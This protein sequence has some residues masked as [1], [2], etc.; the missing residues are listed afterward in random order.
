MSLKID[1]VQLEIEIKNDQSRLKMREL[2]GDMKKLKNELKKLPE[3]TAEW[4]KKSEELRKVQAQYDSIIDKIGLTGLS[5]KEL[6]N[7]QR[8]LNQVMQNMDP[9]SASYAQLRTQLDAVN[10][11]M[12]TLRG[13]SQATGLSMGKLADGFNRYFGMLTAFTA[14]FTG[15]FLGFKK[16]IEVANEYGASVAN[17]SAL[18]GLAGD[19]L[20]WLSD[21]AKNLT[22]SGTDSGIA[23][24][25]SA[26]EIVDSY[27][28]MGSAK[29]ELLKNKEALDQVTQQA[30]I[31]AEAAKMEA[32]PAIES[33]ANTMNQFN[34][35]A[36][37]AGRFVNV[38]AAG[39]KEGAAE[40]S[41]ISDSIV[42][43]GAA[44]ASA[45]VSVEESVAMIEA[46]SE[47][48]VKGEI[49]GTALKTMLIRLQQQTDDFNPK[50]VGLNKALENLAGAN[51]ST[52]EM[53]KIFGQESLVQAQ[54]LIENHK[55]V[56]ELE[57]AVTGT[58]T[59][60]E[61]AK[62]NTETNSAAL[63]RAKNAFQLTAIELGEKLAPA[64]TFSTS[65]FSYL[66]KAVVAG[67][68]VWK[69]YSPEIKTAAATIAVYTIAVNAST[70]ADKLKVFWN[71]KVIASF[72]KL[73]TTVS[74]NPYAALLA[75]IPLIIGLMGSLIKRVNESKKQYEGYKFNLDK[76]NAAMD[77]EKAKIDTVFTALKNANPKSQ[78]RA[79]LIKQINE[80]YGKYLP[81]LLSE[82]S[83]LQEIEQ[84]Q[85]AANDAMMDSIVLKMKQDELT[86]L[87]EETLKK[88]REI[89]KSQ[90][91]NKDNTSVT[92]FKVLAEQ[93][94]YF[95]KGTDAYANNLGNMQ[96]MVN[97]LGGSLT[98][99][100]GYAA[101]LKRQREGVNEIETAYNG[102]RLGINS[103]KNSEAEQTDQNISNTNKKNESDEDRNKKLEE[104]WNWERQ[105]QKAIIDNMK[106][107]YEKQ[108]ALEAYTYDGLKHNIEKEIEDKRIRNQ[109][110]EQEA[111]AHHNRLNEIN[112]INVDNIVVEPDGEIPDLEEDPEIINAILTEE[113][114]RKLYQDTEQFKR[115]QLAESLR[116][117]EI[118]QTE[119]NAR[120]A[121][122][123]SAA[124]QTKV[125]GYESTF[126]A[127]SGLLG[128]FGSENKRVVLAQIGFDTA[129][130]VSS[131]M[132]V[133]EANPLN[134]L[135]FGSAG[136]AQWITGLARILGNV[137]KAK[138]ILST[139]G[140]AGGRYPVRTQDGIYN[141]AFGG[142]PSTQVVS[143]PTHF[144]AGEQ[145]PEM[146]VDGPTFKYVRANYP[147]AI[148]AIMHSRAKVRGFADGYYGESSTA[149]QSSEHLTEMIKSMMILLT[150]IDREGVGVS[151]N[152]LTSAQSEVDDIES[153]TRLK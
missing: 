7:R 33:L 83:S 124:W 48:G 99:L 133:A 91:V 122:M 81:N 21:Q 66:M 16:T 112:A 29:P 114:K 11:R 90:V 94:S 143:T 132:K 19:E 138:N 117:N 147:D 38:L 86:Q 115:D 129:S 31:M 60:F 73:K 23:I 84:A 1:R 109:V 121:A 130:A 49:A 62:I 63:E 140:F 95:E 136:M 64:L 120:I 126:S 107:G 82:K 35:P 149:M 77:E 98:A 106:D 118:S 113:Y 39:S 74:V 152:K 8:E 144:V 105:L 96:V 142:S 61:Q 70:I 79:D 88:Q 127:L 146:I 134:S 43:F 93:L 25:A 137:A 58:N 54:I 153:Q 32:T 150:K 27:T 131:L 42:K 34:A 148:N 6:R 85:K 57:T 110:L 3:G 5:M 53:V 87:G 102:L 75:A 10:N 22:K 12:R 80:T 37:E 92:T 100:E 50:V 69:K 104:L 15:V 101:T 97:N 141:V 36:S 9:R 108:L 26:Q 68:E 139:T 24:T 103:V 151:Y 119:Y 71:E 123:D 145:M 125:S 116:I 28:K 67:I 18:T 2:E 76:V 89:L 30:L 45:N 47:K 41:D 44:A 40:I 51:L 4:I 17:L 65:G 20:N 128:E 78:E 14:S 13:Q 52:A 135:T 59:A 46:L 56:S 55:R 111:I 72:A